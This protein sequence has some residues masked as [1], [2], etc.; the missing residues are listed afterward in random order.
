MKTTELPDFEPWVPRPRQ[1]ILAELRSLA[2]QYLPDPWYRE[3]FPKIWEGCDSRG[4]M[5]MW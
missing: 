5:E 2:E 1:V 4:Q 3:N